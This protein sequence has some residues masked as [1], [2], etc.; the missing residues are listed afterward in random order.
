MLV[1]EN[2]MTIITIFGTINVIPYG[3][4]CS[5]EKSS[6]KQDSFT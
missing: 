4:V 1:L 6:E 3:G 2:L 5:S